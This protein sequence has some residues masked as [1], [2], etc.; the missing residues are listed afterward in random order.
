MSKVNTS[1]HQTRF[2]LGKNTCWSY[3]E[4]NTRKRDIPSALPLQLPAP[5]LTVVPTA[6][7]TAK[8]AGIPEVFVCAPWTP[9]LNPTFRGMG[10]LLFP[11]CPITAM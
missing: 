3:M 2:P 10:T 6:K 7:E 5:C 4:R 8:H 9:G 1:R 11:S